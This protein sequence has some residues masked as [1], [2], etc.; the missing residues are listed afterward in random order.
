[1][2]DSTSWYKRKSYPHFDLPLSKKAA[3]SLVHRFRNGEAHGF[4]P[5]VTYNLITPRT[6]K[7]PQT[8][9]VAR[10][11]QT[12][13]PIKYKKCR[14]IAYPS[15]RDGYI[16]SYYKSLLEHPYEN[17]LTNNSLGESV[18][19]FR[20]LKKNNIRLA[21]E[22]FD[23][24]QSNPVC[25]II[26]TDVEGFFEHID[27]QILKE[28]WKTLLSLDKLPNDHY[29][30]FKALTKFSTVERNKIYQLFSLATKKKSNSSH[31]PERICTPKEFR[32]KIVKRN[33]VTRSR[34][35]KQGEGIPQ[36]TSL[37]PLLSN[38]YMSYF[39]SAI[40]RRITFLG[41]R[42]WRYCDDILIVI[43]GVLEFGILAYIDQLL[44]QLKLS[45][46]KG[47]TQILYSIQLPHKQLQYLGFLFNG[48]KIAVRSSS[49]HRYHHKLKRAIQSTR[50]RQ[51]RESEGNAQKAPLWK[52]SLYNMYSELPLRGKRIK[53]RNRTQ[54]YR[55]NFIHYMDRSAKKMDSSTIRR[56][57]R[58]LLKGLRKRI[59]QFS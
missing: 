19:A 14:P 43:P 51:K 47:K 57:R 3:I 11:S 42:Y 54:K 4:H 52:Q 23:F 21:K 33:K 1:M 20:S 49:I 16:F 31:G 48:S 50:I 44:G 41:G 13:Q 22:V 29:V 58:R 6:R 53:A 37:S 34:G 38:M 56:Q 46:S 27:H 30:V 8:R 45:R 17:W 25:K 40:H 5:L 18:T 10:D 7:D 35:W 55:G 32:E 36:G 28:T 39:D 26:A 15:H 2:Y 12:G 59:K 9:K 24:I